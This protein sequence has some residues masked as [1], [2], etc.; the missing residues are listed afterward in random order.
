MASLGKNATARGIGAYLYPG[1]IAVIVAPTFPGLV[2]SLMGE[3]GTCPVIDDSSRYCSTLSQLTFD[4]CTYSR[5]AVLPILL[6]SRCSGGV[7]LRFQGGC[8]VRKRSTEGDYLAR[9][10]A[11]FVTSCIS[12]TCT[13]QLAPAKKGRPWWNKPIRLE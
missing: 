1:L 3:S 8:F 6:Q 10:L 11:K 13:R 4:F 2:C 12:L 5:I 9:F 7:Y